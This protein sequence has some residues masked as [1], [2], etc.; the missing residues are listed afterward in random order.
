MAFDRSAVMPIT[1]GGFPT[2]FYGLNKKLYNFTGEKN[3]LEQNFTGDNFDALV[4]HLDH[5]AL[6]IIGAVASCPKLYKL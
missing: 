2:K 3:Y 5:S 6:T 4:N 1:H